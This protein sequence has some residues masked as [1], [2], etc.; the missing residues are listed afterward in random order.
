MLQG[1]SLITG[2]EYGLEWNGMEWNGQ[3]SEIMKYAFSFIAVLHYKKLYCIL[4]QVI[5]IVFM[6]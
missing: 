2:L 1:V 6:S 3:S 4:L 5:N